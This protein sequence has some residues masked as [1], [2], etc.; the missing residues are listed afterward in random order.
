MPGSPTPWPRYRYPAAREVAA[1]L[2]PTHLLAHAAL[3]IELEHIA[4]G[5][6]VGQL[7]FAAR[8]A[9]ADP[10]ATGDLAAFLARAWSG[11]S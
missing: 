6:G 4:L 7:A 8:L 5:A 2:L 9:S 10:E 3:L 11:Q 1:D